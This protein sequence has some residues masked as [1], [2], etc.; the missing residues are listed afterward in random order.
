MS[1]YK[2]GTHFLNC[3]PA[4]KLAIITANCLSSVQRIVK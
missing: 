2:R 3:L 1:S 4:P